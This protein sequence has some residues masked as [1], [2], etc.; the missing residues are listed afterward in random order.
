[1]SISIAR[2]QCHS[3]TFKSSLQPDWELLSRWELREP[4]V[5]RT[6][7]PES[8]P[9]AMITTAVLFR[10][11]RWAGA[12]LLAFYGMG[13]IGEVLKCRRWHL[14]LASDLVDSSCAVFLK[15]EQ[16]KTAARGRP[17][18]QHLKVDQ[19]EATW[20]INFAFDDLDRDALLYPFSPAA[21]VGQGVAA[22][23]CLQFG[24]SDPWRSQRRWRSGR[25]PKNYG[26][27]G[28]SVAN[29]PGSHADCRILPSGGCSSFC[30]L[31]STAHRMMQR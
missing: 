23:P 7:G 10:L 28:D 20:L 19:K 12:N 25:V 5:H 17:T 22:P 9:K 15:L 16:T 30:F 26:C 27:V 3:W 8:L 2:L 18:V 13:R 14:P 24:C 6:P 1:M 4:A 31:L 11:W 21:K 29:A